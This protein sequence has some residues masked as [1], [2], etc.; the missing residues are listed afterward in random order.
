MDSIFEIQQVRSL[1]Y[2]LRVRG[3]I[4]LITICISCEEVP[5][6]TLPKTIKGGKEAHHYTKHEPGKMGVYRPRLS[7]MLPYNAATPRN[8]QPSWPVLGSKTTGNLGRPIPNWNT[9]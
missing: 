9:S 7:H 3:L 8:L 5:L 2:I 6:L 1:L 4:T